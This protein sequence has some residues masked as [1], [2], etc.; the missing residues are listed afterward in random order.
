MLLP[1]VLGCPSLGLVTDLDEHLTE[2]ALVSLD[3]ELKRREQVLRGAAV[4]DICAYHEAADRSGL[5]P[6]PRL[7]LVIDEFATL[8]DELPTSSA[9]WSALPSA[10]VHSVCIWSLRRSVR[11][12]RQRRHSCKHRHP[13]CAARHRHRRIERGHRRRGRRLH[14]R[15]TPGRAYV[16]LAT[17]GATAFRPLE[18]GAS[19]ADRRCPD[20]GAS[21]QLG[22]SAIRCRTPVSAESG[23]TDLAVGRLSGRRSDNGSRHPPGERLV[24][25]AADSDH[26]GPASRHGSR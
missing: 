16:R 18:S 19:G 3:A 14:S 23:P 20:F 24:V 26:A 15:T 1:T 4:Q 8:V 22:T 13:D 17:G 2:R 21:R 11:G 10:A 6:L 7:V 9:D 12:C 25:A 5:P